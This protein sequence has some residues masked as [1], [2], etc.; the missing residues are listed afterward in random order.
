MENPQELKMDE[1]KEIKEA[2]DFIEKNIH[3]HQVNK[4]LHGFPSPRLWLEKE[5]PIKNILN[6]SDT[7]DTVA[8]N[9]F[10]LY[11]ATPYCIK[12][13]PAKCGYC[14]FPVEVFQ[15]MKQLEEYL[16]YLQIEG[17]MYQRYL[18]KMKVKSIY[19]GGGTAN[20][21][22][23]EQ[24]PKIMEIVR[25]VFPDLAMDITITME[26]IPQLY[27]YEKLKI[28]KEHG[29]NRIS[30][31]AQQL[32]DELNQLSGRQQKTKHVF[33]AIEWCQELGLGCNV[34]L[35]FGWPRQTPE[36]MLRDLKKLVETNIKEITHY[37]LN[38]GGPTDFA[39]NRRHELPSVDENLKMFRLSKQFLEEQGFQAVSTYFW[40]KSDKKIPGDSV[41]EERMNGFRTI[42]VWGW[43]FAGLSV[44]PG[45]S[46]NPGWTYLNSRSVGEYFAKLNLKEFPIER[47]FHYRP[48]DLSL[49]LLFR[50]LQGL[51]VDLIEY[52][53]AFHH[54]LLEEYKPIWQA[55]MDRDWIEI[56]E[57][58]LKLIGDG[59]FYT[60]LIQTLLASKRIANL[61]TEF[62]GNPPP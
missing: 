32:N 18:G 21:Y 15:G 20:L 38:I 22:K 39:L 2:R 11:V 26:G 49:N 29:I 37:E 6:F 55:L 60:P 48:T 1:T 44:F 24:Y 46:D 7:S 17:E 45:N 9:E 28:M 36:L 16:K 43:G 53:S 13:E 51:E 42:N 23:A 54:D 62:Y 33:Q 25:K 27:T 14:L 58:K 50:N 57:N 31:G 8:Q 10:H 40:K 56:S 30:M 35:I 5:V 34:D 59:I 12:T 52:Q 41:Y 3:E 47:G 61:K 4:I 19:F